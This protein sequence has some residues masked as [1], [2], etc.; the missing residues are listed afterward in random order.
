[1]KTSR[2]IYDGEANRWRERLTDTIPVIDVDE[3][4]ARDPAWDLA[5]ELLVP[6]RREGLLDDFRF[7][8]LLVVEHKH[9][10]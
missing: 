4:L 1:L 6:S 3:E 8:H 7:E 5:L 10:V 9:G 2:Q